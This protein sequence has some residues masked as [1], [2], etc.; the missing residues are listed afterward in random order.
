[1]I[2]KVYGESAVLRAT[3]FCWYNMFSEGR[4]SIYDEQRSGRPTTTRMRENIARVADI[5][6]EDRQSFVYTHS[7]MDG[8]TKNYRATNSA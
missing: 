1:M 4:E 2:Q 3:V 5:L 7:R 8:N 6:K